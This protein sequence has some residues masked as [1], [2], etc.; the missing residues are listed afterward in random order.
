MCEVAGANPNKVWETDTMSG[1]NWSQVPVTI[2]ET[3]YLTNPE[4]EQKLVSAEYQQKLAKG[5]ADGIE[6]YLETK[7]QE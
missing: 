6:A 3:G 7:N 1:I 5:I 4:E 2:I